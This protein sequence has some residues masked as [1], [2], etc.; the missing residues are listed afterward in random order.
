MKNLIKDLNDFQD[1]KPFLPFLEIIKSQ[2]FC[3]GW[4]VSNNIKMIEKEEYL[5][6]LSRLVV[7][8]KGR[9]YLY[10]HQIFYP[11]T[12]YYLVYHEW[13]ESNILSN[14]R[15]RF[16]SYIY[17]RFN[18]PSP[19]KIK[20]FQREVEFVSNIYPNVYLLVLDYRIASYKENMFTKRIEIVEESTLGRIYKVKYRKEVF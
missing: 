8:K 9:K 15:K 7:D 20:S 3:S 5:R 13:E 1:I 6:L 16:P 17:D 12:K 19:I 18:N 10:F 4:R 2:Y 11:E 14:V